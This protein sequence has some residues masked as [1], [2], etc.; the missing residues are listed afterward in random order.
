MEA[1]LSTI[2]VV[3]L[4]DMKSKF[5][6]PEDEVVMVDNKPFV[7]LASNKYGLALSLIHI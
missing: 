1:H 5:K 7:Q 6:I 3:T 2:K 4:P